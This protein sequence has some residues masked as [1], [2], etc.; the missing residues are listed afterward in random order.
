MNAN[1]RQPLPAV[2][3]RAEFDSAGQVTPA[4]VLAPLLALMLAFGALLSILI[5]WSLLETASTKMQRGEF[6]GGWL[7][8]LAFLSFVVIVRWCVIHVMSFI[9]QWRQHKADAMDRLSWP[10]V[11]IL[12]PAFNEAETIQFALGSLIA[13]DYPHFEIVVVDDGS[14]DDTYKRAVQFAGDHEQCSVRVFRKPNGGKWSALNFGLEHASADM[15]LCIDA[16]SQLSRDSL[17]RLASH[18]DDPN[19]GG[20]SGQITVRNRANL[21]TWLQAFEYVAANGSLRAAQSLLGSVLVVPGPIG[22]YRRAALEQVAVTG[23]SGGPQEPG[24]ASG[25]FSHET[26]AEDFQLSLTVLCLGWR[27]VYEPRAISYTKSPECVQVLLN[28][29]YRWFRGTM[30]VLKIY[31]QRLRSLQKSPKSMLYVLL[32]AGY[33]IDLYILPLFAMSTV[34]GILVAIA[35]GTTTYELLLFASAMLMLNLMAGTY[36]VLSQGDQLRILSV[37]P[38]YDVYNGILLNIAWVIAAVDEAR[39]ARMRW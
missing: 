18:L 3:P 14:S 5:P 22:L 15:I 32:H 20:V 8:S 34:I 2:E 6:S 36:Y 27:V 29:R 24:H 19:V 38:L 21:V 1:C 39:G 26:F 25:P 31:R 9:A 4:I 17:K 12:V 33:S 7:L 23:V 30:Q 13:L 35:D 16:D 11:S 10:F 37:L 28:Q